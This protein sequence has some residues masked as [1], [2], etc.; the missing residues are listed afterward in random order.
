MSASDKVGGRVVYENDSIRV[1]DDIVAVGA[2]QHRHTHTNP[3]LAVA[4]AG[5]RAETV[6]DDGE[7]LHTYEI[8]PGEV[9]W[10]GPDQLPAT[11][12][13][14]NTGTTEISVV[15]IELL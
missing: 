11:H 3:Y 13:L 1:W 14:R 15:I 6:G 2:T 5:D 7:V 8:E 12:A 10:F 9:Y 4:I